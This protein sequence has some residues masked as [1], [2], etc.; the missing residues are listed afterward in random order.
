MSGLIQRLNDDG[1]ARSSTLCP[2]ALLAY[3]Q[4]SNN[5]SSPVMTGGQYTS[6]EQVPNNGSAVMAVA[7]TLV[8]CGAV[9][10]Y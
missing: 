7:S 9:S 3:L 6:V 5:S 1:D 4:E 8:F 2:T 10:S